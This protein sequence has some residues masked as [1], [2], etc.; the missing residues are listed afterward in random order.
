MSN[1]KGFRTR[2]KT[3]P[4]S[5]LETDEYA[6]TARICEEIEKLGGKTYVINGNDISS[7]LPDRLIVHKLWCGVIEFKGVETELRT[8][9]KIILSDIILRNPDFAFIVRN[10]AGNEHRSGPQP[11]RIQV[12]CSST[13]HPSRCADIA[14]FDGTGLGLLQTLNFMSK[15]PDVPL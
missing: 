15:T 14:T 6:F 9:Q 10:G 8:N 3:P 11:Y 1:D 4:N 2:S 5:F 13:L 7:G 12:P